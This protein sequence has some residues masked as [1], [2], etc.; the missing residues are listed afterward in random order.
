MGWGVD[1]GADGGF[2]SMD[3]KSP[4]PGIAFL[5]SVG[6]VFPVKPGTKGR[7]KDLEKSCRKGKRG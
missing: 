6:L 4:I 5:F 2:I 1:K 7:T 3:L